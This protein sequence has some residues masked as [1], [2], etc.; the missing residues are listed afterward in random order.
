MRPA[1]RRRRR[2]RRLQLRGHVRT[3]DRPGKRVRAILVKGFFIQKC[4]KNGV[5]NQFLSS[6]LLLGGAVLAALF[7]SAEWLFGHRRGG[8][9][10][11]ILT[12]Y[13]QNFLHFFIRNAYFVRNQVLRRSPPPSGSFSGGALGSSASTGWG[14]GRSWA[15]SRRSRRRGTGDCSKKIGI[16]KSTDFNKYLN[17]KSF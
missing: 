16:E 3:P 8:K 2:R 1:G 12:G 14:T 10:A 15:G 9:G 13:F 11:E 17:V 4:V 5:V 6:S 7:L